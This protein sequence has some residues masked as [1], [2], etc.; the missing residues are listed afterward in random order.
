MQIATGWRKSAKKTTFLISISSF[1][2]LVSAA[3]GYLVRPIR[4][5][6]WDVNPLKSPS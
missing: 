6:Q 2:G 3:F 5:F 1:S 4:D